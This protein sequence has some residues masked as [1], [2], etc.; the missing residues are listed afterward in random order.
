MSSPR[1]SE[2]GERGMNGNEL[3]L[4]RVQYPDSFPPPIHDPQTKENDEAIIVNSITK[5]IQNF[6]YTQT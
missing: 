2:M 3:N 4:N 6:A 5:Q 1:L